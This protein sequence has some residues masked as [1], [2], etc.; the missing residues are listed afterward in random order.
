MRERGVIRIAVISA[1]KGKGALFFINVVSIVYAHLQRMIIKGV[2]HVQL[3]ALSRC[4][5]LHN[6]ALKEGARGSYVLHC[7]FT[8]L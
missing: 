6:T 2:M 8:S 5:L 1:I 4:P 7:R 3:H